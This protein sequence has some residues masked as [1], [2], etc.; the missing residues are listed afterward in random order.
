MACGRC[1]RWLAPSSPAARPQCPSV[2]LLPTRRAPPPP[3]L[4]R[5]AR[6][7]RRQ[8]CAARA[9]G[10]G[11]TRA[12]REGGGGTSCPGARAQSCAR[13]PSPAH[14]ACAQQIHPRPRL[15]GQVHG[16]GLVVRAGGSARAARQSS[17]STPP[18]RATAAPPPRERFRHPASLET[19]RRKS[20][21]C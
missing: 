2:A 13:A 16:L 7:W 3:W 10:T 11:R 6:A 19:G 4:G 5:S 9:G 17:T 12:A 14:A 1:G 8:A 20:R 21:S 18:P 15:V